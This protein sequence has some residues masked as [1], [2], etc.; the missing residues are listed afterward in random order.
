M[1]RLGLLLGLMLLAGC[2]KTKPVNFGQDNRPLA[3]E[4]E[5]AVDKQDMTTI[6]KLYD[7]GES[8]VSSKKISSSELAVL[9]AC[10]E[11]AQAGK[12]DDAKKLIGDSVRVK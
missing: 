5:R 11:Y 3:Q 1:R 9:K 7:M 12:W 8:R 6:K 2:L 10:Y 4:M